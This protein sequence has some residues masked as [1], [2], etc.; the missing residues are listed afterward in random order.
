[1]SLLRFNL[2]LLIGVAMSAN[3]VMATQLE[4]VESAPV[5]QESQSPQDEPQEIVIRLDTEQEPAIS[6]FSEAPIED[7][8]AVMVCPVN[9]SQQA[10]VGAE[11]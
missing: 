6:C 10:T 1:M 9:Q 2:G 5:R 11:R 4:S 3:L 8:S 7:S